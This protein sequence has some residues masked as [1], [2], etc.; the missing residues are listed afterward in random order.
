MKTMT[1]NQLGGA[2]N[3]EFKADSFDEI[4]SLSEQHA[5][6]MLKQ[7]DQPHLDAMS[8]MQKLMKDPAA[9]QSWFDSKRQIF[10]D[11]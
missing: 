5:M 8:Q 11:R 9:M 3:V 1:C 6:E 2:C 7:Q 10:D 4:A